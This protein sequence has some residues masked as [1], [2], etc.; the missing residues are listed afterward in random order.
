MT[1]AFKKLEKFGVHP[2]TREEFADIRFD[3]EADLTNIFDWNTHDIFAFVSVEYEGQKGQRNEVTIWDDIIM[4]DA[5]HKHHIR[6]LKRKSEYSITDIN[7]KLKGKTLKVFFN[8]DHMPVVG[9]IQRKKIEVGEFT[10]P[11][12]HLGTYRRAQ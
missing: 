4:R 1:F 10:L 9:Y 3:L 11:N 6:I 5:P 12:D 7:K 2:I 8:Y